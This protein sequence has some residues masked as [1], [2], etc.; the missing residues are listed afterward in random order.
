[1]LLRVVHFVELRAVAALCQMTIDERASLGVD[2]SNWVE[3]I[4]RRVEEDPV[5]FMAD[6]PDVGA[7]AVQK[8]REWGLG[9]RGWITET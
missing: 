1:M 6:F 4:Y 7:H 2:E 9:N 3:W 8:L 5:R